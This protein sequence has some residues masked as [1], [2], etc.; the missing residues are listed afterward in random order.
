MDRRAALAAFTEQIRRHPEPDRPDAHIEYDSR[1]IRS[2]STGDGWAG[3]VWSDL[4]SANADATIADQIAR[5]ATESRPWEWKHYS[6]DQ[7]PDLPDRLRAAG[8]VA[9]PAEALL[10]AEIADLDLDMPAPKN[11][12]ITQVRN[13]Q[14]AAALVSVHNDVFGGDHAAVGRAVLAR[15]PETM[16]AAIAWAGQTPISGARVEFHHGTEFASLW[17]G[18]TLPQWRGRGVFRALVAYRARLAAERGFRY[19]QVDAMPDSRPILRRLG[20]AELAMTTPFVHSGRPAT[21]PPPRR[22]ARE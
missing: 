5:F 4:D 6:C 18:G 2:V 14:D 21:P 9:Q 11:I 17:G 16:L 3:V 13:E 20:F 1:V 7:P 15:E 22:S 12:T 10:V 19:L 8:F